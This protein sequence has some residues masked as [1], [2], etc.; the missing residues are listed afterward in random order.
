[1]LLELEKA[2][3]LYNYSNYTQMPIK[4]Q[5]L[6]ILKDFG[7]YGT[8]MFLHNIIKW[9]RIRYKIVDFI[10]EKVSISV[11]DI[12]LRICHKY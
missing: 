1:M 5:V 9:V 6:I 11:F 12:N 4:K 2:D 3:L 10:T 7:I 8:N